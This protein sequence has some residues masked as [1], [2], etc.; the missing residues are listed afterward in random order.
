[1]LS[2]HRPG[3]CERRR[4]QYTAGILVASPSLLQRWRCVPHRALPYALD[5][6]VFPGGQ[7]LSDMAPWDVAGR[8]AVG[9]SD[10]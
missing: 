8:C 6:T 9:A 1:M 3:V 7:C 10:R 4:V 2:L 5:W